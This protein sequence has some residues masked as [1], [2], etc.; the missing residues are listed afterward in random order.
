MVT[1]VEGRGGGTDWGSALSR[2]KLLLIEWMKNVVLMYSTENS[3][4]YPGINHSGK[5]QKKEHMYVYN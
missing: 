3:I 5:E 4:Q 2:C 1:N